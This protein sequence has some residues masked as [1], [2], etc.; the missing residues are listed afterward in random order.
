[1]NVL[2]G[3]YTAL[4]LIHAHA[5]IIIVSQVWTH[6]I[7]TSIH[8]TKCIYTQRYLTRME[9]ACIGVSLT[10]SIGYVYM[11]GQFTQGIDTTVI[12]P[13]LTSGAIVHLTSSPS[14]LIVD[15]R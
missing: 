1:M 5:C 4:I 2:G 13:T 12:I 11:H 7:K 14:A 6:G 15:S 8:H 10:P 9:I 3:I